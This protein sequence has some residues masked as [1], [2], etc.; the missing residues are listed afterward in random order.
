MTSRRTVLRGGAA[1]PFVSVPL[2]PRYCNS[3]QRAT[4]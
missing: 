1:L 2:E 3:P 4:S